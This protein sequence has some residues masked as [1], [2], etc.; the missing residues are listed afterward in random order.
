M[1]CSAEIGKATQNDLLHIIRV[2]GN[3]L[4]GKASRT[5]NIGAVH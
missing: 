4:A 3:W 5:L 1:V 2:F